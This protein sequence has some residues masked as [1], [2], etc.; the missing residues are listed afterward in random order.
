MMNPI[1]LIG[2]NYEKMTKNERKIADMIIADPKKFIRYDLPDIIEKL[3]ISKS[4]MVRFCKKMGFSGYNE[5]FY[6]LRR[7]LMTGDQTSHQ[8]D[9]IHTISD[10][11][12]SGIQ[13]LEK[14][15]T[16]AEFKALAHMILNSRKIWSFGLN[17]SALSAQQMSL[18]ALSV[19]IDIQPVINDITYMKDI[20]RIARPEDLIIIFTVMDNTNFYTE[21]MPLFNQKNV[22]LALITFNKNLNI[23]Q[24][25]DHLTV[26]PANFKT[27]GTFYDEQTLF[28]IFI[29]ILVHEMIAQK[30]D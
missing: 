24:C 9:M 8:E 11:Y 2:L 5:Y 17:R 30:K 3:Q 13:D 7:F 28:F 22:R 14:N 1:D 20:I 15:L 29:E 6:E 16:S 21:M 12:I 27:Y 19:N 26:L 23:A 18:R 10:A 4:A 25:T